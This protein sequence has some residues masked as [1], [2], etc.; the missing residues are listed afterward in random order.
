MHFLKDS[1]LVFHSLKGEAKIRGGKAPFEQFLLGELRIK[2]TDCDLVC[3]DNCF[4]EKLIRKGFFKGSFCIFPVYPF[5]QKPLPEKDLP[6]GVLSLSVQDKVLGE[7]IFTEEVLLGKSLKGRINVL[8]GI[9][10]LE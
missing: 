1:F 4:Y 9:V 10:F 6:L 8:V 3:L 5:G 2:L 7:A